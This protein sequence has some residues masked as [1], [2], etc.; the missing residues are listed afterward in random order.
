ML[1]YSRRFSRLQR[2]ERENS[3]RYSLQE[4]F[5][6]PTGRTPEIVEFD[7]DEPPRRARREE[8]ESYRSAVSSYRESG[9]REAERSRRANRD[10][11]GKAA[12]ERRESGSGRN[13]GPKVLDRSE[14]RAVRPAVRNEMRRVSKKE[15]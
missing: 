8:P 4:G 14:Q 2:E 5:Q 3:G 9:R 1:G 11:S 15:E 13:A 12:R 6:S 10:S 7:E